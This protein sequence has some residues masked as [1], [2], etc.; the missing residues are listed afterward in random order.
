[1]TDVDA[2]DAMPRFTPSL[3]VLAVVFVGAGVLHLL[4]P[5]S[6]VTIVPSWLPAPA[7][8][9]LISGLCEIAGG[10]GVLLPATRVA[11]GWGL[12]G[13]LIA[14]FPANVQM[15]LDGRARGASIA[16]QAALV[17]RLPLQLGLI[18]WVWRAAVRHRG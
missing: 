18:W 16:W 6:Y 11:A 15:F 17:A 5:D 2:A 8:L 12:I 10:L 14:V 3:V 13:L 1:M 7:L 9:V 4:K